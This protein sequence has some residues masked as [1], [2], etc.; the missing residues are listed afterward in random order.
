MRALLKALTA[1]T[2][3]GKKRPGLEREVRRLE[4]RR[5]EVPYRNCQA[6]CPLGELSS[7]SPRLTSVLSRA[8]LAIVH[9]RD[10]LEILHLRIVQSYSR[11]QGLTQLSSISLLV[12]WLF[13]FL[14]SSIV[15]RAPPDLFLKYFLFY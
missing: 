6:M 5:P 15:L 7:S 4:T 3:G 9:L 12:S 11:L 2:E 13:L 1:V 14:F 10:V 8:D